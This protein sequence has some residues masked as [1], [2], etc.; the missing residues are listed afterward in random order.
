ML[1]FLII[2]SLLNALPNVVVDAL[3]LLG[4]LFSKSLHNEKIELKFV[5]AD[6]LVGNVTEDK[7]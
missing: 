3:M 2:S 6:I 5:Q 7:E 4:M 1:Q